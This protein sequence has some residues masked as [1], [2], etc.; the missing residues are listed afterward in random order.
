MLYPVQGLVMELIHEICGYQ[1]EQKKQP[2]Y[3]TASTNKFFQKQEMVLIVY[4]V[5]EYYLQNLGLR[6]Y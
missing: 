1:L 3:R 4:P 2:Q 6:V 5:Y